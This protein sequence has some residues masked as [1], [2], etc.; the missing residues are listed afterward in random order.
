MPKGASMVWQWG[1]L[2]QGLK[3]QCQSCPGTEPVGSDANAGQECALQVPA[4]PAATSCSAAGGDHSVPSS[5]QVRGS[6]W[7]LI[8]RVV[9]MNE[10]VRRVCMTMELPNYGF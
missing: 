10:L 6:V 8:K 1:P 4:S 9:V 5:W 2:R 3:R 7:A